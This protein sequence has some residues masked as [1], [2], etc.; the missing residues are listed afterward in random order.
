MFLPLAAC[1]FASYG[2]FGVVG[3]GKI[4]T[5]VIIE[6]YGSRTKGHRDIWPPDKRPLD[7]RPLIITKHV[8]IK[9][10]HV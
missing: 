2:H 8:E 7:R 6:K 10:V 3:L 5:R 1:K 4:P 9:C